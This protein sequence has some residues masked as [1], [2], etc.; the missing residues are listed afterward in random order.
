M[1]KGIIFDLDGTLIDSMGVWYGVD[2]KFLAENNVV[3]P[4]NISEIMKTLSI[5]KAAEFFVNE[6]KLNCTTEYVIKRIEKMVADEYMYNIQLKEG[7]IE[8]LDYLDS[9]DIPY[10]I[11]T[12]TYKMLAQAVLKRCG[13][14]DRFKFI[15]TGED[16]KT[17]KTSPDIYFECSEKLGFSP[18]E[19]MIIE[20][21][22]HCVKTAVS[23]G[24][25]TIA[26]Y[27]NA[28]ENEWNEICRLADRNLLKISEI[29]N[30]L[31]K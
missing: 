19:T 9:K 28:A 18:D 10:C 15:L 8:L 22:L 1:I 6:F 30:E 17:G 31:E 20:D 16:I 14:Y 5:D 13:I 2:R 4:E 21:S 12:A 7:V 29:K 25:Y 26:V 24:F 11:A 3:P 27:D 23:A